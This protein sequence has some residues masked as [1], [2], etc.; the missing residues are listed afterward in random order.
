[1]GLGQGQG[2]DHLNLMTAED[3]LAAYEAARHRLPRVDTSSRAPRGAASLA[4]LADGYDAFFLD[5]FGVLNIGEE[6]IPGV[7][8]RV[9]DLQRAGKRVLVVSNAAGH[10]H[11]TLVRKYASLGYD[12]APEDIVTSRRALA[13]HVEGGEPRRW[14]LM[15][16]DDVPAAEFDGPGHLRLEDDP[17][18]YEKAEGVLMIGTASWTDARQSLLE[19]AL[20]TRPRPVLVGNPDIVAPRAAGFSIEPGFYAHRLADRTGIE[21]VFFGK[22]F[23]AIYDLAFGRLGPGVPRDRV[24]MVGDSL[25]TDVLGAAA[26][27]IASALVTGHGFL[28]GRD[29]GADIRATGIVPDWVLPAP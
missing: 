29:A 17:R 27:G 3:A 2:R 13:R 10:P 20:G 19:T 21:P 14:G 11:D 15:I 9:A 26:A 1:M 24:L 6:A 16:G 18:A 12:F 28:A 23:A 8:G 5:A 25:H 4:D 7:P 22:P